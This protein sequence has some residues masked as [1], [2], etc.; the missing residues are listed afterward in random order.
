MKIITDKQN[1][2]TTNVE[3]KPIFKGTKVVFGD[4][5]C[6]ELPIGWNLI[7]QPNG[8][9]LA[10]D[11]TGKEHIIVLDNPKK[12]VPVLTKTKCVTQCDFDNAIYF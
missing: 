4:M 12:L 10:L 9:T 5:E 11:Q 8:V 1:R 3:K 6:P 7:R 2:E